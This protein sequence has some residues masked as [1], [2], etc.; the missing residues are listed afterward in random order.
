M[1][2][3]EQRGKDIDSEIIEMTI[4]VEQQLQARQRMAQG[5]NTSESM[6]L[7]QQRK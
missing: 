1:I 5:R 7:E 4:Q 3:L 2:E 6:T